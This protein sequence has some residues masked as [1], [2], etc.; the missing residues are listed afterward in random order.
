M[1]IAISGASGFIG[2]HLTAYLN[3]QGHTIIPLRHAIFRDEMDGELQQIISHC[4][5]II[6][7]AGASIN[8]RWTHSYM[9]ELVRSRI[10]VTS[11]LVKAMKS[12]AHK[13]S[14]FISVSAVGYYSDKGSYDEKTAV[15]GEGFLAEL[16]HLWEAEAKNCPP[17]TQIGRAHV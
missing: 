3:K 6:N 9:E 12:S 14:F 2:T 13:P 4:D 7:L 15:K 8:H 16:C 5:G 17:E 11:R 10:D 1:N